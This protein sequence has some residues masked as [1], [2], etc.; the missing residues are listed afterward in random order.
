MFRSTRQRIAVLAT[1]AVAVVGVSALTPSTAGAAHYFGTSGSYAPGSFSVDTTTGFVYSG[2][3]SFV[4]QLNSNTSTVCAT[5]AYAGN[6]QIIAQWLAYRWNSSSN[7]WDLIMSPSASATVA[8][9]GCMKFAGWN[10]L[11]FLYGVGAGYYTVDWRVWWQTT[12]GYTLAFQG[13][14]MDTAADYQIGGNYGSFASIRT[15]AGRAAL[16]LPA[17]SGFSCI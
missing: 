6:Q 10:T 16:C 5:R 7:R 4:D 2:F 12:S 8:P 15:V 13:D 17:I 1:L 9:G 14:A 3:T 11:N